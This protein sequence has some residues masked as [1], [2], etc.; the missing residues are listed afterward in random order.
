MS[1]FYYIRLDILDIHKR[2]ISYCIKAIDG[3][4]I[5]QGKIEA[6]RRSLGEWVKGLP[7]P[8]VGA[9]EAT[10]LIRTPFWRYEV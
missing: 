5:G 6:D 7:G 10:I 1:T 9:M 8:R 3:R 4:L 2:I